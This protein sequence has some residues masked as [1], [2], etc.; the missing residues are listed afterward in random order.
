VMLAVVTVNEVLRTAEKSLVVIPNGVGNPSGC[1]RKEKEGF[2]GTRR[3]S[4]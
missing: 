4:E 2:L 1:D 3:A